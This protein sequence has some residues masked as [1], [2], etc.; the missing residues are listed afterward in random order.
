M[1]RRVEAAEVLSA[2]ELE[3]TGLVARGLTHNEI[4]AEQFLSTRTAQNH[5]QHILT[6]LGPSNPTQI[7]IWHR[8][9]R[10]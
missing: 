3:V 4:A 10:P 5:V 2:R 1:A 6:N 8:D 7:A 9:R